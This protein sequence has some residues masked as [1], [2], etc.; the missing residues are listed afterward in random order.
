[1]LGIETFNGN[2][3][4]AVKRNMMKNHDEFPLPQV[5][6]TSTPAA[7]PGSMQN[8]LRGLL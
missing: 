3:V 2:G 4:F 6:G 7:P 1:M 8:R 5:A